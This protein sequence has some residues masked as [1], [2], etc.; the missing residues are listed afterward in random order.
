MQEMRI[1][2]TRKFFLLFNVQFLSALSDNILKNAIL[3]MLTFNGASLL[4]MSESQAVNFAVFLFIFPYLIFSSY[5]GKFADHYN[6]ITIIKIIKYSELGI[7]LIAAVGFRCE[8]VWVLFLSLFLMGVHSSFFGPIKYSILPQYFERTNVPMA[9]AYIEMGTFI[10][11]LIGQMLGSWFVADGNTWVVI[12]VLFI[13]ALLGLYF[14]LKMVNVPAMRTPF[15]LGKNPFFDSYR[16]YKMV[17]KHTVLR[18]NLHAIS[19]FWGLGVFYTTQLPVLTRDCFG[20]DGHVFSII[21]TLFSLGIGLGSIF[22]AKISNGKVVRKY[23]PIGAAFI[24]ILSIVLLLVNHIPH[25]LASNTLYDASTKILL[26]LPEFATTIKGVINFILLFFIGFFAGFYSITCYNDLQLSA[27]D[28]IRSQVISAN[29]I[30][31]AVYMV[32]TAVICSSLL[33]VFSLWMVFAF[34]LTLNLVFCVWYYKNCVKD[35]TT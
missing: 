15:V 27:P 3:V 10:A 6:K 32:L 22:C 23:V 18:N 1:F 24:S 8:L 19:W 29:N 26:T 34:M 21:L 11:V 9:N 13:F 14:S 20:G 7:M 5:A 25:Y 16:M 17:A 2:F 33:F 12:Y 31:N 30:L 4:G 28:E 35:I